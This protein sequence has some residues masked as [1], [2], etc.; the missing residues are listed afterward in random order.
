MAV[1]TFA[2]YWTTSRLA[3]D[4][5][6]TGTKQL[7]LAGNTAERQL[8]AYPGVIGASIEILDGKVHVAVDVA[9]TST[10]PAYKFRHAITHHLYD[11]ST[12]ATFEKVDFKDMQWDMPPHSKTTMRN[13]GDIDGK[14]A[15][16]L[17]LGDLGVVFW[18]R[19]EYEDAFQHPRSI[20][21]TYRSGAFREEVR[22][23]KRSD[24]RGYP[25]TVTVCTEPEPIS[26]ESN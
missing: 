22:E 2:L 13:V 6:K 7:A 18:G 15:A 14:Q 26:Y 19:A 11:T 8:R 24:G 21:F 12:V 10:T 1:V 16:A 23:G 17:M 4:A 25:Y 5:E 3:T 9:N 20:E